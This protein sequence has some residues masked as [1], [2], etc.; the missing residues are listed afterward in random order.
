MC[1][2]YFNALIKDI[3]SYG[4]PKTAYIEYVN[5]N[6]LQGWGVIFDQ[7]GDLN[8]VQTAVKKWN[9]GQPFNQ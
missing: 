3:Q 9:A 6:P 8:L 1:S 5:G 2:I 4:M 7:T